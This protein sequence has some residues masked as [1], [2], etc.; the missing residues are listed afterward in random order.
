MRYFFRVFEGRRDGSDSLEMTSGQ[1][2]WLP[3]ALAAFGGARHFVRFAFAVYVAELLV[4]AFDMTRGV[5]GYERLGDEA[6][7]NSIA[8]KIL[9]EISPFLREPFR[10]Q[11]ELLVT[12]NEDV[13]QRVIDAIR[14]QAQLAVEFCSEFSMAYAL[15]CEKA[16][17]IEREAGQLRK[18]L[19]SAEATATDLRS[20]LSMRHAEL[21]TL[22]QKHL[23]VRSGDEAATV[24]AQLR[25]EL[26]EA[27]D[28]GESL[29]QSL[30]L[31]NEEL[32]HLREFVTLL[33]EDSG[34]QSQAVSEIGE[35][36]D[37]TKWRV[38]F[39]GGH[40]RMHSKLRGEMRNSVFLHPDRSQID[41]DIFDNADCAIFHIG[42]C[43]HALELKAASEVRKRGLRAGY[44]THV[45][46][47]K[48]INDVRRGMGM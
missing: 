20:Q 23:S 5:I 11:L 14:E 46:V 12:V 25:S 22:R 19:V 9:G 36:A 27:L 35:S 28:S 45:N 2:E 47:D 32:N 17:F 7:T 40:E 34:V 41:P 24:N 39:V 1:W 31:V 8:M 43:S 26:K 33:L 10:G 4:A 30:G 13:R 6:V 15:Q 48:V 3:P 37:P 38:V 21:N 42:Y 16:K 18:R 29:K 44:T